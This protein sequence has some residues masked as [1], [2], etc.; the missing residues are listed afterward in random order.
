MFLVSA[1]EQPKYSFS[2]SF[3]RNY[4]FDYREANPY[5]Q[6]PKLWFLSCPTCDQVLIS[7]EHQGSSA[8]NKGITVKNHIM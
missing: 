4:V 6:N 5:V 1:G 8:E 2:V 3:M 7:E